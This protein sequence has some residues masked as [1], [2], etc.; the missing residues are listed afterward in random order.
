MIKAGPEQIGSITNFKKL[1][2]LIPF[3]LFCGCA[4]NEENA[5]NQGEA[6]ESQSDS[7]SSLQAD[8]LNETAALIIQK[9]LASA[10]PQERAAAIETAASIPQ[11]AG[12]RFMPEVQRL[13]AD[14]YVPVRFAAAVAMGD[15]VFRPARNDVLGLLKDEDQNVRM[16]AVYASSKLIPGATT[17]AI[18]VGLNSTDLRVRANA[19][20]LLGKT[21]NQA[22]LPFLYEAIK[23]ETSDDRVRLNAAEAIAR[24]GD[25]KIYQRLWAMLISAYAD[26]RVFGVRAMG[27]LNTAQARDALL[28]MLKDDIVE[29]RLVAAEQL[30]G[31]R[32]ITGEKVVLDAFDGVNGLNQAQ[33]K[34]ERARVLTLCARAIGQ[35]RT[36]ALK[37]FLP[38]LLKNEAVPVRLAAAGA[39]FQCETTDNIGQ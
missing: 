6:F 24:L 27:A 3:V 38:E 2:M 12:R 30:G 28:T 7:T 19:A 34:E 26:D 31:M 37:K 15:T 23:D 4:S 10:S 20:F 39:V 35:I 11:S 22:N 1:L 14:E 16:A 33:D 25:N 18:R 21:G 9:L 17:E 36:P 13:L 5:A 32:D 8:N 29:V